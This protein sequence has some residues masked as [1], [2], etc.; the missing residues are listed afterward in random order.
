MGMGSCLYPMVIG[1][2][3]HFPTPLLS[4]TLD[5][6][7]GIKQHSDQSSHF[8]IHGIWFLP[9]LYITDKNNFLFASNNVSVETNILFVIAHNVL[10]INVVTLD[11]KF[12]F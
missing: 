1:N 7:H 2:E 6:G 8:F 10:R 3:G 12:K 5:T 11:C 4:T 9:E